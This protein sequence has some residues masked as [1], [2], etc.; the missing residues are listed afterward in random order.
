MNFDLWNVS[1]KT[2][3]D[4]LNWF[5]KQLI[6]RL[7]WPNKAKNKSVVPHLD[8]AHIRAKILLYLSCIQG[9]KDE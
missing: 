9:Q 3:T 1:N 6:S 4:T 5:V 7:K 2:S 8:W